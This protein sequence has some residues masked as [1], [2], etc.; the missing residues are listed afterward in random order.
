MLPN[1]KELWPQ[2]VEAQDSFTTIQNELGCVAKHSYRKDK[3]NFK[4]IW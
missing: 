1:I 4:I 2:V 3:K